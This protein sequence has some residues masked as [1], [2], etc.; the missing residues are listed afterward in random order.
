MR[1]MYSWCVFSTPET[2]RTK[3]TQK[4]N[5][6]TVHLSHVKL[7]PNS[8]SPCHDQRH[9]G[10]SS[11]ARYSWCV[12]STPETE[13]TKDTQKA[14]TA[15]KSSRLKECRAEPQASILR[16]FTGMNGLDSEVYDDPLHKRRVRLALAFLTPRLRLSVL[17]ST[18]LRI[19]PDTKILEPISSV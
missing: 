5:T 12:F 4:E 7:S 11:A 15:T 14:T 3:D 13:R 17:Y 19:S 2:E 1:K 6:P 18:G 10:K 8:T 16:T 9:F